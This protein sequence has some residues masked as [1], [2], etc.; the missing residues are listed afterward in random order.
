MARSTRYAKAE[1]L[2]INSSFVDGTLNDSRVIYSREAGCVKILV[3]P[4]DCILEIA[5]AISVGQLYINH[6]L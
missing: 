5:G 3:S 6:Y 4:R 1:T 2:T